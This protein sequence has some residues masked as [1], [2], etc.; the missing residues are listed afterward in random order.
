[1]QKK[2]AET[3]RDQALAIRRVEQQRRH[4]ALLDDLHRM[5]QRRGGGEL[6]GGNSSHEAD[7]AS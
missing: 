3:L 1:M 4:G 6:F 5:R 7:T 2:Q